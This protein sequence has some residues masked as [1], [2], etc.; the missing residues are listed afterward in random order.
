M[1]ISGGARRKGQGLTRELEHVFCSIR[2]LAFWVSVSVG[3]T[4]LSIPRL[5]LSG[6]FGS[7]LRSHVLRLCS[8]F[9]SSSN[10][11]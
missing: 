5:E 9:F 7:G 11:S 2:V 1:P 4:R 10:F 3:F 8:T 6:L